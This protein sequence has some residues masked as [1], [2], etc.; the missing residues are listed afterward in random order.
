MRARKHSL[1]IP[2]LLCLSVGA[3]ALADATNWGITVFVTGGGYAAG[4]Y[5][6]AGCASHYTDGLDSATT[7]GVRYFG[8]E[9]NVMPAPA[10]SWAFGMA[11]F[12]SGPSVGGRTDIRPPILLG[13]E[14]RSWQFRIYYGPNESIPPTAPL[15]VQILLGKWPG[16]DPTHAPAFTDALPVTGRDGT[17]SRRLAGTAAEGRVR[18]KTGTVDNVRAIAGYVETASGETLVFSIIANN[19]T[20]PTSAIDAAADKALI[21]LATFSRQP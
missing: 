2:V 1:P 16:P 20:V 12:A 10:P 3:P 11:N 8:R 9:P 18:A 6:T 15:N 13:T 7:Y 21:R 19:F 4:E 14:T 5:A 17:L